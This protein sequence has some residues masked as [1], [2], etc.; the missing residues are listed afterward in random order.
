MV[1]KTLA[2]EVGH[3][4]I[5]VNA[6]LPGRIDTDRIRELEQGASDPAQARRQS[7]AAIPLRRY[8]QPVE[9]GRVATF[10]LSPA[11]SYLSGIVIPVDGGATRAL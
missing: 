9:F 5:R 4:G 11:A 6:L 10:V 2:D 1:A 8:G 3:R 7:E